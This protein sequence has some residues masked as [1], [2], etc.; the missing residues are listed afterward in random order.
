MTSVII[1]QFLLNFLYLC[2]AYLILG[3]SF[4]FIY[5]IREYF[6]FTYGVLYM[7]APYMVLLFSK[8]LGL[9]Y[10]FGIILG[11]FS[12]VL[13][14]YFVDGFVFNYM[15]KI[16]T[17]KLVF[18]ITS[19]GGYIIFQNVLS[20]AF[21]DF[22][23]T[24]RPF[25][26]SKNITV[27]GASLTNIQFLTILYSMILFFGFYYFFKNTNIGLIIRAVSS[28]K[29][30]AW[31]SGINVNEIMR[32]T[33]LIGAGTAGVSGILLTIDTDL[34]PMI[35]MPA[36]IM[37]F[38]ITIVGGLKSINGILYSSILLSFSQQLASWLFGS[39]WQDTVAFVILVIVLILR[40][41]SSDMKIS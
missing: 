3:I 26:Y 34:T 13:L 38:I 4:Y 10:F 18:M 21:G 33:Y 41:S 35:G 25:H 16:N 8:M 20:I 40:Y 11:I 6:D 7:V 27:I 30:L 14:G 37:A 28:S 23:R 5:K 2:S 32:L 12:S 39:Q 29:Q 1:F 17:S 19:M 36:M 24:I 9:N 22:A 31:A 15:R